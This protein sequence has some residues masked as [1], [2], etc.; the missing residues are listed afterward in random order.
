MIDG[1]ETEILK[2]N[3][4]IIALSHSIGAEVGSR[5]ERASMPN[6]SRAKERANV[7]RKRLNRIS[8][9]SLSKE[10]GNN[11]ILRGR[12]QKTEYFYEKYILLE[13]RNT[14]EGVYISIGDLGLRLYIILISVLSALIGIVEV[15]IEDLYFSCQSNSQYLCYTN[16]KE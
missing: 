2:E 5:A 16:G 7:L 1:E 11:I 15:I 3:K 6:T 8:L 10:A 4:V 14:W 9:N 13:L 12:K